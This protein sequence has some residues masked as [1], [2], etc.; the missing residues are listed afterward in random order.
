MRARAVP[1]Q[2][3]VILITPVPRNVV[4]C[5]ANGPCARELLGRDKGGVKHLEG[6]GNICLEGDSTR[7]GS[8]G[9]DKGTRRYGN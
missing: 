6:W 7:T 9:L 1:D 5:P 3:E 8:L 2:N 4:T